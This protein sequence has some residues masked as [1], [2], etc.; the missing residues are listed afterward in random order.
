VAI[1]GKILSKEIIFRRT[2]S[3]LQTHIYEVET[4]NLVE[5]HVFS[6]PQNSISQKNVVRVTCN[7]AVKFNLKPKYFV[8]SEAPQVSSRSFQTDRSFFS[9]I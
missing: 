1:F 3:Y 6:Y 5:H 4:L 9:C 2:L 7:Q 8:F